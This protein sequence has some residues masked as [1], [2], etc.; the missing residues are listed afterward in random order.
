MGFLKNAVNRGIEQGVNR[1]VGN[2]V[3]KAA[4]PVAEK[5]ANK[6]ADTIDKS[7]GAGAE[8]ADSV[9]EA[10]ESAG[11]FSN[12]EASLSRLQ[13][14]ATD[15]ANEVSKNMTVKMVDIDKRNVEC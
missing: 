15:Y 4:A 5:W 7:I 8:A 11:G 9:N 2:A 1:A 6:V 12:L 10:V 13:Q 14:S 3:S